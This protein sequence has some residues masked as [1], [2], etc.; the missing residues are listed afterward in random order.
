[1]KKDSFVSFVKKCEGKASVN[2]VL[3]A[4][5]EDPEYMRASTTIEYL[6]T[7]RSKKNQTLWNKRPNAWKPA[8]K[9]KARRR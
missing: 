4:L 9:R 5:T 8:C 3:Q 1:M 6:L 7:K 2:S